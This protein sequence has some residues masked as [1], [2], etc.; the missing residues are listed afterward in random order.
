MVSYGI[1]E[2]FHTTRGSVLAWLVFL[3]GHGFQCYFGV[4]SRIVGGLLA[5]VV[6]SVM[7]VAVFWLVQRGSKLSRVVGFA[8]VLVLALLTLYWGRTSPTLLDP[9]PIETTK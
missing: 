6:L 5:S 9:T 2:H 3:G 7:F 1:F 8:M 4:R